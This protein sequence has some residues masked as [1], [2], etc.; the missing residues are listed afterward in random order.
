ML[1]DPDRDWNTTP[2]VDVVIA[3]DQ[4]ATG[5][6]IKAVD[7]PTGPNEIGCDGVRWV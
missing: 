7:L 3:H 1:F 2:T 6:E 4:Q 5:V